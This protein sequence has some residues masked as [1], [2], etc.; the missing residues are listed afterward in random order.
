LVW[1]E[2]LEVFKED[3]TDKV[4][5]IVDDFDDHLDKQLGNKPKPKAKKSKTEDSE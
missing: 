3:V 1:G 2:W 4:M 5:P